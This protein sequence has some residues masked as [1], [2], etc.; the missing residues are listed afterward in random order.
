MPFHFPR[1]YGNFMSS[2]DS[3][4]QL[5]LEIIISSF[6]LHFHFYLF[7]V[8]LSTSLLDIIFVNLNFVSSYMSPYCCLRLNP[9][10]AWIFCLEQQNIETK[11]HNFTLLGGGY[12]LKYRH[13]W[14][15]LFF[16]KT[17]VCQTQWCQVCTSLLFKNWHTYVGD[18]TYTFSHRRSLF[19]TFYPCVLYMIHNIPPSI[20]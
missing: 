12:P 17:T 16:F 10:C 4:L 18:T 3:T 2:C 6:K 5:L 9:L 19:L 20:D 11:L 1:P 14:I 7:H 15:F 13:S 8:S